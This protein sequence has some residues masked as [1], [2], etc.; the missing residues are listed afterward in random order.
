[1]VLLSRWS[2]PC[3]TFQYPSPHG[4]ASCETLLCANVVKVTVR[5]SSSRELLCC[6]RFHLNCQTRVSYSMNFVFMFLS[7]TLPVLYRFMG[8]ILF[9]P[10]PHIDNPSRDVFMRGFRP[11]D[12]FEY[13]VKDIVLFSFFCGHL[14]HAPPLVRLNFVFMDFLSRMAVLIRSMGVAESYVR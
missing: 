9:H 13:L 14:G 12:K 8:C 7:C 4:I 3:W 10:S 5:I 11:G 2:A 6:F 1:M